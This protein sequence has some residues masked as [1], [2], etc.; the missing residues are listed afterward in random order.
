MKTAFRETFEESGLEENDL[1][2][3]RN[4][5]KELNYEARG[6]PKKV[7]YWLAELRKQAFKKQVKLSK[8]H[9][10]YRW[11]SLDEACKHVEHKNMQQL[12]Q[13]YDKFI[14]ENVK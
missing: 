12:L 3:F 7:T 1:M 9:Q 13:D 6:K 4:T 11:L 5:K 10:N 2:I 8:E 14:H